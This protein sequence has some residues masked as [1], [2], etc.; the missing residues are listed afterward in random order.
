MKIEIIESKYVNDPESYKGLYKWTLL[1]GPE[2][3]DEY[4]GWGDTVGECME[5]II[6][7]RALNSRFYQ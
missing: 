2:W 4:V 6:H 7:H 3:C 5:K 1:D